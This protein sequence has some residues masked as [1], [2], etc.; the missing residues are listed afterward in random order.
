MRQLL[1]HRALGEWPSPAG[2]AVI[3]RGRCVPW[4]ADDPILV[5]VRCIDRTLY[6]ALYIALRHAAVH[7]TVPGDVGALALAY[8]F[9]RDA[10]HG[11]TP[12]PLPP[13]PATR[14]RARHLFVVLGEQHHP[15][16]PVPSAAADVADHS[17]ARALHRASRS[18]GRS[19]AGKTTGCLY[20][21]AEQILGYQ[22]ADP[23][24][25]IGGLVLEVKGDFC[26]DVRRMLAR[27][28]P[29]ARLPGGEPRRCLAVQPAAQRSGRLRARV[30][31]C[32]RC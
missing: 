2:V 30:R 15:L 7:D 10:R 32:D 6:R 17:R 24:R 28:R 4:R 26:H 5:L 9:Y 20:P 25:R 1:A 12:G 11:P 18:S 23:A 16:K 21:Y 8:I 14:P 29:G 3:L 19:A 22:A 13:Y 31:H 27:T